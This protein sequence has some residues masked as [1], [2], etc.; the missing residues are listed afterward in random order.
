MA[1][2]RLEVYKSP[3]IGLFTRV[4][5]KFIILPYGFAETKIK[6]FLECLEIQS[7]VFASI[8]GTRLIGPMVVLNNKGILVSS[9]ATE[10]EVMDLKQNTGLRVEKLNSKMTA[11]GNL[12]SANDHGAIVSPMLDKNV[13]KQ[14]EDLLDV[15]VSSTSIGGFSQVGALLVSTNTGSAIHPNASS[16]EIKLI[17]ETLKVEV[18]PLTINGGVPFLSSGIIANSKNVIVGNL[19]SGPELIMIS[20]AFKA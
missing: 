6:K 10:E 15:S 13:H 11:I 7:S 4:T 20:R 17:S 16:D 14:I 9:I 18:E 8:G 1:I 2:Y 3:N 12:I 5:D 19:T